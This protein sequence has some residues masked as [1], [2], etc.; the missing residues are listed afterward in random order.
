VVTTTVMGHMTEDM[1][2]DM[3]AISDAI[4]GGDISLIRATIQF[5]KERH[6]REPCKDDNY[7]TGVLNFAIRNGSLDNMKWLHTNG[8]RNHRH[9][10][11]CAAEV[12]NLDVMK[13][14]ITWCIPG[15]HAFTGACRRGDLENMIWMRSE[16]VEWG[17]GTT[18]YTAF[19]VAAR[20]G[21]LEN[22]IWMRSQGCPWDSSAFTKAAAYGRL[23]NMKWMYSEG[24]KPDVDTLGEAII[25]GNMDNLVWL[26]SIDCELHEYSF[27]RA[28]RGG[29]MEI[30]KWLKDI[31][32]KYDPHLCKNAARECRRPE[33][34]EWCKKELNY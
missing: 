32:C 25:Y 3:N 2:V 27:I 19:T 13:W 4:I 1:C 6:N 20:K 11:A 5:Y 21:N 8:W 31:G 22:M 15:R 18:V 26:H 9:A 34:L 33:V 17:Q 10:F 24:L 14:L 12:G 30:L 29:D 28:I 16:G 23:K 7:F